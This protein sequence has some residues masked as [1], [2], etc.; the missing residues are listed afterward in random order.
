MDRD[1]IRLLK[2]PGGT[3]FADLPRNRRLAAITALKWD[4]SGTRLASLTE[5]GYL[6][7]R[8]LAP[9][10]QWLIAHHVN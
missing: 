6:Q 4:P 5:D 2:M 1:V 3:F 7:V 9:W 10:Q 8:N